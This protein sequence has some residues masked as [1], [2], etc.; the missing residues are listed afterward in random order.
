M[1]FNTFSSHHALN[2]AVYSL[3]A[4]YTPKPTFAK[5]LKKSLAWV[6]ATAAAVVPSIS[7]AALDV[8]P[9]KTEI[10]A[11]GASMNTI[12]LAILGLVVLVV[13]FNLLKRVMR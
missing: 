11:N 4:E 6:G 8:A 13:G 3:P 12:M 9:L 5:R 7:Y 2:P 10:E 1:R